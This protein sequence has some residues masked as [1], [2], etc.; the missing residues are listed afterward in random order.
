MRT[1]A[2]DIGTNTV[3]LLVADYE[4]GKRFAPV[5][6]KEIITRLGESFS[7]TGIISDEAMERTLEALDGFKKA[8]TEL[9]ADKTIAIATSVTRE[10]GNG[11]DFVAK[12]R[13]EAGVAIHPVSGEQEAELASLGALLPVD[14]AFDQAFIFDIG[15][16][17]TEFIFTQE[18][19]VL[20]IESVGLGVVHLTETHLLHDPPRKRELE[21][22][23]EAV[24]LKVESV[25]QHLHDAVLYP[26]KSAAR[27]MLIGIA[28]TPTTLAAIDLALAAYDRDLVTNHILESERIASIF[29]ALTGKDAAKRLLTPGLQ[30]GREDLIIPGIIIVRAIMEA[31]GFS[32]VRVIDSGILEGLI[33]SYSS[34]GA[35]IPCFSRR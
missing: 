26:F 22:I 35:S 33:L 25:R 8:I 9:G 24:R 18:T 5:L 23:E 13:E 30:K 2:I 19:E 17:S 7:A 4:G 21:A 28:G 16:G 10:A 3:R 1:A 31:F 12:A 27:V 32:A 6:R 14:S 34:P 29:Q 11:R 15:G 20:F